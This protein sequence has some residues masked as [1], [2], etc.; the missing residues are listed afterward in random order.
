ME[1]D[2]IIELERRIVELEIKLK[3]LLEALGIEM[4]K[5]G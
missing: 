1:G 3:E 2:N 4:T 5:R